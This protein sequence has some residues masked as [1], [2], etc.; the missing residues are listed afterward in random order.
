[1]NDTSIQSSVAERF[2]QTAHAAM[3]SGEAPATAL[4]LA[5][6]KPLGQV[7]ASFIVAVNSEGLWIID[8]HVAHERILFE[9]HLRARRA[10][11]LTGQRLL[12]PIMLEL[13]PRQRVILDQ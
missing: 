7:N 5:E 9:Q 13:A 4:S 12:V 8:Q 3:Q 6:L 10:G 2:Q 11:A 1:S